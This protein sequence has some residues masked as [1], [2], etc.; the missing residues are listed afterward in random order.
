MGA[1]GQILVKWA[2]S[3]LLVVFLLLPASKAGRHQVRQ[4]WQERRYWHFSQGPRMRVGLR[5]EA[6]IIVSNANE[7]DFEKYCHRT[8]FCLLLTI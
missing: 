6:F 5:Y 8:I 3:V 4:P 1:G 7:K 2:T